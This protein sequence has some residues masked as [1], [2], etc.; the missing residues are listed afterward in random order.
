MESDRYEAD[1]VSSTSDGFEGALV[2]IRRRQVLSSLARYG[3][4]RVLE[5]GCG[6]E[7]VFCH[8]ADF[9]AWVTVEPVPAF[10]E[11][12]SAL[13]AEDPRVEVLEA[14]VEDR[15][16]ELAGR[17]FDFIVVSSLLHE[18]ARPERVLEVLA[19]LCRPETTVHFS[20]PNALSFHRLLA[21]EMG[22][23]DD[24][25]AR[26]SLDERFGHRPPVDRGGLIELLAQAGFEAIESGSYFVK[27]FTH[28]QMNFLL[29]TKAFPDSLLQGLEG[30]VRFMPEHGCEVFANVRRA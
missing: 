15:D 12:A 14:Y 18:V 2:A 22:L 30:I 7:P 9:D 26:S 10:A 20:V 4:R 17:G 5:V 13:A 29:G 19:S 28:E 24:V 8:A 6:L 16:L 21:V 23:I 11:G 1:Y 25:H 3:G 27:P